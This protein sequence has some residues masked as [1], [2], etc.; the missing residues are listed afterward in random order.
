[1]CGN[2][3]VRITSRMCEIEF[4]FERLAQYFI[5]ATCVKIG[6]VSNTDCWRSSMNSLLSLVP[7]FPRIYSK[8]SWSLSIPKRRKTINIGICRFIIGSLTVIG[9]QLSDL[10]PSRRSKLFWTYLF[11]LTTVVL[12]NLKESSGTLLICAEYWTVL[13]ISLLLRIYNLFS[14]FLSCD[15]ITFSAPSIMKYPPWS[16]VHSPISLLNFDGKSRNIQALL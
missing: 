4:P 9:P 12:A 2:K 6:P 14:A 10:I 1:M 8:I 3:S 7:R 11:T 15:T 13:S 16:K 5:A